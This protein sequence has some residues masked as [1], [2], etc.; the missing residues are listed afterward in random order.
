MIERY[1]RFSTEIMDQSTGNKRIATTNY[2]VI[3]Y[4][5]TDVYIYSKSSQRL[6]IL[7]YDYYQDQSLWWVIARA[8]NLGKGTFNIPPGRRIRIPFPLDPYSIT[9]LLI[10]S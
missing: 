6:D 1:K 4:R 5:D 7:A 2:P 9:T 10:N 8:N 3:P